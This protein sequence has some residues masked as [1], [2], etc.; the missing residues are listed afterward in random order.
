MEQYKEY[1][2]LHTDKT[3][4]QIS[5]LALTAGYLTF[6]A[7]LTHQ[8]AYVL[9]NAD[10]DRLILYGQGRLLGDGDG[11]KG[12]SILSKEENDRLYEMANTSSPVRNLV[13]DKKSSL[14]DLEGYP[15]IDNGGKSIGSI[16]FLQRHESDVTSEEIERRYLLNESAYMAIMVPLLEQPDLY[17]PVSYQDGIII[18]SGEGT[19][20][21][22]NDAAAQMVDV[23]G[24]DK[25]LVGTSVFGGALKL[26]L[27]KRSILAH[28]GV[29]FEETYGDITIEQTLIPIT[30]RGRHQRHILVLKDTTVLRRTEQALLVKNSVIKEIHHRV[31]NNLQIIAGLLRMDARRSESDEVK[32]SLQEAVSRIESMAL[33]HEVVSRYEEDYIELR[34]ICEELGR[35]LIQSMVPRDINVHCDYRGQRILLDSRRA[36]YVSLLIN[37]LIANSLEHGFIEPFVQGKTIQEHSY[38][39]I[40][41]SEEDGRVRLR[42]TDNGIGFPANF[43]GKRSRRL[44]LRIIHSLVENELHGEITF[45]S[46]TSGG[47]S[48]CITFTNL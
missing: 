47:A 37:E 19:I 39:H 30:G 13:S 46:G 34:T 21:Y 43:D 36:G 29:R 31:K 44:G 40:Q 8:E 25:R 1:C 41:G 12:F 9:T 23:L 33:V 5:L 4:A 17:T 48:V 28:R 6:A 45:E 10:D 18:F 35:L 20:I 42:V 24:F 11:S 14:Y 26:S 15:I 32:R 27:V 38:V 3:E 22:A 7:S 16:I 2:R